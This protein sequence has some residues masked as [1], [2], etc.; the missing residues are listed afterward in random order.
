MRIKIASV[1][2]TVP[3]KAADATTVPATRGAPEFFASAPWALSALPECLTQTSVTHGSLAFVRA[4]LPSGLATV[5]A[6]ATLHYGNCTIRVRSDDA[7]VTRGRDRFHIPPHAR[8][9]R[10]DGTLALLRTQDGSA[11]LRTYSPSK[12]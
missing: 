8:F 5:P 6:P 10:G 3:P 12:L 11:E 1:D 9:L 4:H 2:V 7:Y